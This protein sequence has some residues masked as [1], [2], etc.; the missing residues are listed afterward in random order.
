MIAFHHRGVVKNERATI[1]AI[2]IGRLIGHSPLLGLRSNCNSH[3][4]LVPTSNIKILS[5]LKMSRVGGVL[6]ETRSLESELYPRVKS[7]LMKCG[8][9]AG[10]QRGKLHR[11]RSL[12]QAVFEHARFSQFHESSRDGQYSSRGSPLLAADVTIAPTEISKDI[13]SRLTLYGRFA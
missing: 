13:A 12:S 8:I 6:E 3:M 4:A 5:R 7:P 2:K 1:E 9:W 11:V 10:N